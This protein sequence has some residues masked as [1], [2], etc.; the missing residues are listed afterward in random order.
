MSI[1]PFASPPQ[2]TASGITAVD[3]KSV[4]RIVADALYGL[5]SRAANL[6][7]TCALSWFVGHPNDLYVD[8][9]N[10]GYGLM[11][12]EAARRLN[13]RNGFRAQ[14]LPYP[15]TR[16]RKVSW[17]GE[18]KNR[19]VKVKVILLLKPGM[20]PTWRHKRGGKPKSLLTKLEESGLVKI[21]VASIRDARD[22]GKEDTQTP[23]ELRGENAKSA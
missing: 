12:D 15:E 14:I 23:A 22:Y 18:W 21:F 8:A 13:D 16:Y 2:R 19:E 10:I 6:L 20:P 1:R 9:Y 7:H 17:M 3:V 4:K 11:T 5:G